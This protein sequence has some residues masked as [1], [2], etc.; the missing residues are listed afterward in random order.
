M[1]TASWRADNQLD[2][3]LSS[4]SSSELW[5]LDRFFARL[6]P[7]GALPE[8]EWLD[9]CDLKGRPVAV[10]YADRHVP[11]EISQAEWRKLVLYNAERAIRE[12]GVARGPG[13]QFTLIVDRTRSGLRNQDPAL[14]LGLQMAHV[15]AECARRARHVAAVVQR[16]RAGRVGRARA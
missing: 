15:Q 6:K 2:G 12:R 14:A 1:D 16:E 11:G 13:G 4:S 7:D 5:S 3:I 10:F 8:A 9:G